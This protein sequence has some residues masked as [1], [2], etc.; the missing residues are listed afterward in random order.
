V[1]AAL[2]LYRNGKLI[3]QSN[4]VTISTLREKRNAT[5]SI[6]AELPLRNLAAGEYMAQ[7]TVIDSAG[8][9]FTFARTPV[10]ILGNGKS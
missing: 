10:V 7:F 8:Q 3:A 4:P 1:A 6:L 2:A 5:A 9:K